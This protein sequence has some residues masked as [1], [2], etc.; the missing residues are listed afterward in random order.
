MYIISVLI[1]ILISAAMAVT[2]NSSVFTIVDP[3]CFLYIVLICIPILASTGQ[4]RDLNNAFKY[5]VKTRKAVDKK[6]LVRARMAVGFMIKLLWAA[7][8]FVAVLSV[9]CSYTNKDISIEYLMPYIGIGVLPILYAAFLNL[10]LFPIKMRL[11]LRI[12]DIEEQAENGG[13]SDKE[14]IEKGND[15]N[16]ENQAGMDI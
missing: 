2:L 7:G 9:S 4:I 8:I 5:A 15:E 3:A 14:I 11:E 1:L 16:T 6:T 10:L 13:E 12:C